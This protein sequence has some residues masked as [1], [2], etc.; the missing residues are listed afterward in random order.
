[1]KWLRRLL[2]LVLVVAILILVLRLIFP[3]PDISERAAEQAIPVSEDTTLGRLMMQRVAEHP[4]L[5]G[6]APLLNGHDALA[7]R[8]E[9]VRRAERSI[10]VQY[11]IWHD[12]TSGMMLLDAL[13]Q[14]A[15]R[16]VQVRLLLD[17]NGIPGLDDYLAALNTR[18]NLAI[19][20]FNPSTVRMPKLAG[21][22]IDFFRMNR[23]MHNKAMIVD[24]A[25]AIVGGRNIGDEYFAIGDSFFADMDALAIGPIVVQATAVFDQYWN[26]ASVFELERV[27]PDAGD[28]TGID[29]RFA[30]VANS[31]EARELTGVL[32]ASAA[33]YAE[34]EK[35]L[36]WTTVQLVADDPVKGQG[37]AQADQ[38]MIMRLGAILGE[39]G[40]RLDLV[41]PYL[42]PGR[43]G[44]SYFSELQRAG[45]D[46]RILTNA[47]TTTDVLMVHAGYSKYRREMLE[48]GIKL[49]EL[50]LPTD[51][52]P[53]SGRQLRPMGISGSSLHAKTFAVDNARIFIGSFN[54]DP[55]SAQL[56][57]EMGFLIDS[58][59][60]ASQ[61]TAFFDGPI[62]ES[63]FQ[64]ELTPDGDMIW[65]EATGDGSQVVYQKEP[66]ANW[67]QQ[68]MLTVIGLLPV[69]WML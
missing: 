1:M 53:E 43:V 24:G 67:F 57:C 46:V 56:N 12:D 36:E 65:R 59:G 27:I 9:L 48:A 38:L 62:N 11:Y 49:F 45:V 41:S 6:V 25:A 68:T 20:L 40:S 63:T 8:L 30:E 66:G 44:T 3:L 21:Y 42:I 51:R 61:M 50:K 7:S 39:M 16:G 52:Q 18:D 26:S 64:P 15:A 22:A 60:M 29:A 28:P 2:D 13:T 17:D 19:R 54:F 33:R 47:M 5:T 10:D 14:A 34:G 4:G 35:F 32:R 37:I 58:P 55:R 31:A 23:R 69:E